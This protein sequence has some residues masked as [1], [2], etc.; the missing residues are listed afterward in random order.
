MRS[1][2]SLRS[3]EMT[4]GG[5]PIWPD[6]P[7]QNNRMKST[8]SSVKKRCKNGR[9]IRHPAPGPDPDRPKHPRMRRRR[10]TSRPEL[11][12]RRPRLPRPRGK[13]RRHLILIYPL[14]SDPRSNRGS[15]YIERN[16]NISFNL[17]I[18]VVKS[19]SRGSER[20]RVPQRDIGIVV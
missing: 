11:P 7:L 10:R 8:T 3:L 6:S 5:F 12:P 18:F 4:E 2:D 16:L 20:S 15:F 14:S 1:L 9:E 13:S 19:E 17:N